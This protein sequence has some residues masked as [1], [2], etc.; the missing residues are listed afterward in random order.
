[1]E[2]LCP[3]TFYGS[4]TA[5]LSVK[6]EGEIKSFPDKQNLRVCY[7]STCPARNA[8]GRPAGRNEKTIDGSLK[9]HEEIKSSIKRNT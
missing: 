6:S 2:L 9:P 4:Y 1:M 8:K 5:K 7:Q 3:R